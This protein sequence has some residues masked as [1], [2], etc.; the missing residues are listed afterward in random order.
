MRRSTAIALAVAAI[1]A[2][3]VAVAV[4]VAARGGEHDSGHDRQAA[5]AERGRQVMPFD[6]ERSTHRFVKAADGGV[7]TVVSDDGDPKQVALIRAHLRKEARLFRQGV[8]DDAVTIHRPDMPGVS[9]IRAG[10]GRIDITYRDVATGGR[11]RYR[12]DDPKLADAIHRWF[13]AQTTDHGAH[14]EGDE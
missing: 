7:Q 8:F 9:E 13:D 12:T 10:T 4:A 2:A 1:L 6:L 5:V 11:L 14:A 3:A